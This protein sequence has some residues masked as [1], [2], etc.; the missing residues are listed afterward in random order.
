M[1]N[2]AACSDGSCGTNADSWQ[3]DGACTDQ[4]A[5]ANLDTT[6]KDG[7]GTD[8]NEISNPAVMIDNGT[9]VHDDVSPECA[10]T[11]NGDTGKYLGTTID[12]AVGVDNG[13]RMACAND[14]VALS[15]YGLNESLSRECVVACADANNEICGRGADARQYFVSTEDRNVVKHVTGFECGV[16]QASKVFSC[17]T[18]GCNQDA[19]VSAAA[20]Q[21]DRRGRPFIGLMLTAHGRCGCSQR[22]R[23]VSASV[24][25]VTGRSRQSQ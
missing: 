17:G 7:A 1:A 2:D 22:C 5:L 13:F 11:L 10:S 9:R 14:S 8:E 6:T 12:S 4:R 16:D 25:W 15:L 24:S 20:D 21:V 23:G 3:D 19:A 18:Q